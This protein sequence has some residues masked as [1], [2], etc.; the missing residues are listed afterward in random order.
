MKP[1]RDRPIQ[2]KMLVMTLLICGAVLCV[3]I[4]ALFAFQVLNFRSNFQRDTATLADIIA[5]NSTAAVAFKDDTAATEVVGSLQAKPT[6][7]AASLCWPDGSMFAHYGRAEDARSLS[8]F[9]PAGQYQFSGGHLLLT[10]TVE[11]K[12]EKV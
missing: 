12:G 8:Q 3:A 9:P 5:K 6:V 10:R 4:V 1:L 2:Q 7:L 11:W